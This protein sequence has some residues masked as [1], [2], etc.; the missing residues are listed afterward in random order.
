MT[1]LVVLV[2]GSL[3]YYAVSNL[4]ENE[5]K[6][7]LN[8]TAEIIVR[9]LS[10]LMN[11]NRTDEIIEFMRG[12]KADLPEFIMKLEDEHGEIIF[13]YDSNEQGNEE[14]NMVVDHDILFNEAFVGR[15]RLGMNSSRV[16]YVKKGAFQVVCIMMI[17][18]V[19]ALL[20]TIKSIVQ[21]IL[22]SSLQRVQ[23]GIRTIADGNYDHRIAPSRYGD[24][25][26]IIR[27]INSMA[28]FISNRTLQLQRE[29]SERKRTEVA[30]TE[31]RRKLMTLMQSLPGMAYRCLNDSRFTMKFVSQGVVA[32]TGYTAEQLVDN[33]VIDYK[34]IIHPDDLQGVYDT[35]EGGLKENRAFE[36][37]YRIV[38]A[39]GETKWVWEAGV[40][41][42]NVF[43]EVQ[44]LEGFIMD[45]D[46]RRLAE[47]KLKQLNE[48]LELRVRERTAD[49]VVT[50][51]ALTQSL[52]LIKE[53]QSRLVE[54]E[55][56]A[57]LGGMVAGMAH[58]INNPLGISVTAASFL[59]QKIGDMSRR[60]HDGSIN[61]ID[62]EVLDVLGNIQESSR[63][64][65]TNLR[66]ASE[67]VT[68]FK[69]VAS[70]QSHEEKRTFHFKSYLDEILL[71][72]RPE[73]KKT[74]V[75]VEIDVPDSLFMDSYP[76]VFSQ[77]ITNLILN[78]IRHGYDENL[79]GTIII[80]IRQSFRNLV[81]TYSDDGRGISRENMAKIYDPFFTTKR[82]KGGSGLG[83]HIIFN[84]V[85][86]TLN[87]EISCESRE[88][89]GTQFVIR[90]PYSP[91]G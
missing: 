40:G 9:R 29:I 24:V 42:I 17:G 3:N 78:S 30:L 22:H 18:L 37:E 35:V 50:N 91:E 89:E 67:L 43:G 47:E 55:K 70:D 7:R 10:H 80:K 57:A 46:S 31:S 84:L 44:A 59:D 14:D 63:I 16:S 54:S 74:D 19:I 28:H 41:I 36:M 33:R 87:G 5:L 4:A 51:N 26:M 48:E 83:L 64:I 58:E 23:E 76:G 82:G 65:L 20:F 21:R 13:Y 71:S 34:Q 86:N 69:R 77:I 85:N 12:A 56:L 72:L 90:I 61:K 32:L 2:M 38:T 45:V 1:T 79:S 53:T 39:T 68:G 75:K 62:Q 25:E 52:K 15:L 27:E 60:V 88:G 49:L 8:R 6:D 73:L 11:E 66:R 81:L